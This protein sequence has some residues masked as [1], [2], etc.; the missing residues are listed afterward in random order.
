MKSALLLTGTLLLTGCFT[1]YEEEYMAEHD[2]V[3]YGIEYTVDDQLEAR[4]AIDN[5]SEY[6][7]FVGT[8]TRDDLGGIAL[9]QEGELLIAE[10]EGPVNDN[11]ER[12]RVDAGERETGASLSYDIEPE[13]TYVITGNPLLTLSIIDGDMENPERVIGPQDGEEI[14]VEISPAD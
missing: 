10:P 14:E 4:L 5:Q 12:L 11:M 9:Y 6:D 1:D 2:D 7:V 3:Y 13:E 8:G